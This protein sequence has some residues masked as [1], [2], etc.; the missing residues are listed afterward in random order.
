MQFNFARL[1]NIGGV[2]AFLNAIAAIASLVVAFIFIGPAVMGDPAKLAEL[3]RVNPAPLIWQDVLKFVSAALALV[4]I[5]ILFL[6]LRERAPGLMRIATGF[7]CLAVLCLVANALGS[8]TALGQTASQASNAASISDQ[9]SRLALVLAFA[10]IFANG[11]WYLLVGWT[12]RQSDIMP[13]WLA[14]LS[15]VLGGLSLLP[16]L[17]VIVLVLSIVWSLG[18]GVALWKMK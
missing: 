9:L 3:A 14:N 18:L 2:A 15:V 10:A 12:V 8:L 7:G 4:L 5:F 1:R 16:P 11:I 6:L 13:R 17:G